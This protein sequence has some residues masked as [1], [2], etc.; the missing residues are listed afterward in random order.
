MASFISSNQLILIRYLCLIIRHYL[1]LRQMLII[2][3]LLVPDLQL[4]LI[5]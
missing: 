4:T 1:S 5:R 2:C 3:I